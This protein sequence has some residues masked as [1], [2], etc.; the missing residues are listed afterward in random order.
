MSVKRLGPSQITAALGRQ[1]TSWEM[2]VRTNS[3]GVV[4]SGVNRE[5]EIFDADPKLGGYVQRRIEDP[6]RARLKTPEDTPTPTQ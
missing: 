4:P 1:R 2:A 3:T 6:A 5:R